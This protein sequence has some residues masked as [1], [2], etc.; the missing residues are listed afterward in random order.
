MTTDTQAAAPAA[1]KPVPTHA[2]FDP[3][4]GASVDPFLGAEPHEDDVFVSDPKAR[5]DIVPE[6]PAAAPAP[7]AAVAEPAVAQDTVAEV[8]EAAAAETPAAVDPDHHSQEQERDDKGRWIPKDRFD[9]VNERRKLAERKVAELEGQKVAAA[10]ASTFDFDSAEGRYMDA[11]LDGNKDEARGIRKEIDAARRAEIMAEARV[12]ATETYNNT[13][14]K[15]TVDSVID[16]AVESF[17]ALDDTSTAYNPE[18]VEEVDAMYA[19]FLAKKMD[20]VSALKKAVSNAAKLHDLV[21]RK[22]APAPAAKP[23]AAAAP[24]QSVA[25]KIAAANAQPPATAD[26][27]AS[28]VSGGLQHDQM[29]DEEFDALPEAT[30]SRMRGDFFQAG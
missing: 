13:R 10:Q 4:T 23:P 22:A 30:K 14:T 28:S 12:V 2:A 26:V 21:D 9:Q 17:E 15:E 1:A 20:P 19:G 18:L 8:P 27:G 7:A 25:Q 11:V 29:S 24:R 5:G 16:A 6:A 3:F